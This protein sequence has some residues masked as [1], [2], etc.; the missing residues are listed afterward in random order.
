MKKVLFV[1]PHADDETLGCGGTIL[2]LQNKGIEVHWLLVTSMSK[3]GGFTDSEIEVRN[4]EIDV[5]KKKYNFERTYQ[6]GF[7]PSKLDMIAKS[8]LINEISS[9]ISDLKPDQ[10]FV[11]FR[12]D[13]HSDHAAV[14]DAVVSSTKTFRTPFVKKILAYETLSETDFTLR[15]DQS[16][17]KPNIFINIEDQIEEKIDV[18]NVYKSEMGDF[19]FPRS[20]KAI[21]ALS[22]LRGAQCGCNDAEAF[23]LL[24]E[25]IY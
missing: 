8:Q 1:A 14:F 6:L 23:I 4:S 2:K 9:V 19:P 20:N 10:V 3:D 7:V 13:V 22:S 11:P 25:I 15:P 5:V 17:F 12:N 21:R 16:T 24:K 18:M